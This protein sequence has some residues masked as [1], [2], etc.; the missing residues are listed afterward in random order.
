MKKSFVLGLVLCAWCVT[1]LAANARAAVLQDGRSAAAHHSDGARLALQ[2]RL[3]EAV[4]AFERSIALDPK[5]GNAYYSLGNVYSELGR[6]PDA[7]AAYRKAV[8][9]NDK[10][11]E[12]YNGLGIALSR[13]GVYA[14]A[15]AAFEEAIDIYP[16]WAE[17]HFHLSEV[18]KQLGDEKKAR[19]AYARAI[20]LRPDYAAQPPRPFTAALMTTETASR[21][22]GGAANAL[23]PAPR[24]AENASIRRETPARETPVREAPVRENP[25][26]ENPTDSA[27]PA[28]TSE[29]ANN[30]A[31]PAAVVEPPTPYELGVRRGREGRYEEAV[32]AFRQAVILDRGNARAHLALGDAYAELGRWRESVDAY[33][34]AARL[35]ENDP[36]TY[37][38]LG[39]AYAK[40]RETEPAGASGGEGAVGV[41]ASAPARGGGATAETE[42]VRNTGP[43]AAESAAADAGFDPTEVYRVGPG[44]VLDVRVLSGG[45]S[46]TTSFKVTPTGLLDFPLTTEPLPVAG[47]TTDTIAARLAA[48]LRRRDSGSNTEIVV[49]VRE[50]VSHAIIVS[51]LVRDPGT[52]IL[53]REGVPLYVI[54]AHAQPL[55]GAGQALVVSRATGQSTEVDLADAQ[56]LSSLLVRPGDVV[57]VQPRPEQFFYIAG[58]VREPG[59]KKFN[60]GLTLTQAVLAAGGVSGSGAARVT[61]S[62]QE[63]GGRLAATSYNL[64]EIGAGQTPDPAVRPGDRIEVSR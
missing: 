60:Q 45:E 39:R 40:L 7:I 8:S 4:E 12:A 47:L 62:R 11:V 18:Q 17:P 28:A 2:G 24:A 41:R 30:T 56:T 23:P 59:R 16:K 38:K 50:Y 29:R 13:R 64:K 10:D 5:N 20:R 19:A 6:W 21:T 15:A 57:T 1:T 9:L 37:Q 43:T 55:P 63:A 49:G 42:R 35:N 33:E 58:A 51:G 26:R 52:K 53:Q 22:D 46:K 48:E 14:Q 61:V 44:D 54:T 3:Q 25:A 31:R 27:R 34:H 36:D 32:T